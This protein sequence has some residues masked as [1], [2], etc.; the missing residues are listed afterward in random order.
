MAYHIIF[1]IFNI[2]LYACYTK[3]IIIIKRNRRDVSSSFGVEMS[4]RSKCPSFVSHQFQGL[5]KAICWGNEGPPSKN[6]Q[7][8]TPLRMESLQFH[9][10]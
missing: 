1:L 9:C 10:A 4:L 7:S 8:P 3:I 5:L 6:K 2:K